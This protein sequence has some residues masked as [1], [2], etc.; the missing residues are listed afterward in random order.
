M[1]RLLPLLLLLGLAPL[2]ADTRFFRGDRERWEH[3]TSRLATIDFAIPSAGHDFIDFSTPRG[4][5]IK[6]VTFVG[7]VDARVN[8]QGVISCAQSSE[9][10]VLQVVDPRAA[11]LL[12]DWGSKQLLVGPAGV[13][14]PCNYVLITLPPAVT[15]VGVDLMCRGHCRIE[16]S[17]GDVTADPGFSVISAYP[18]ERQI[19]NIL[20]VRV[21][22]Q[23]RPFL[24]MLSTTPITWIKLTSTAADIPIIIDN[25]AIGTAK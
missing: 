22:T 16:L 6:G 17:T 21:P 14:I 11:P 12:Y 5:T 2:E 4:L 20:D 15:A 10:Y 23:R 8:D 9:H 1:Y 18:A 3:L 19:G 13:G 24:G 7:V 25:L